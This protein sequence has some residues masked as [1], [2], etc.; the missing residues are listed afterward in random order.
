MADLTPALVERA[1]DGDDPACRALIDALTPT[2][3]A[4]VYRALDRRAAL[5]R[6]R[7]IRQEVLDMTQDVFLALFADDGRVLRRWDPARGA[8]LPTFV[9]LV[10]EREVRAILRSRRRSPW[11][12]DP[13]APD[14]LVAASAPAAAE[15]R[16]GDKETLREVL[17]RLHDRLSDRG[18]ELFE[19]LVVQGR[20]VDEVA[21]AHGMTRDAVY[22]W[23]SRLKKTVAA[24][25][26]DLGAQS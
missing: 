16:V 4:R 1:L 5:G 7:V 21:A 13:T 25:A 9:G 11:T 8:A 2:I 12:E 24:I 15:R 23:R 22:T 3:R 20:P 14:D 19:A 6:G 17:A 26:A 10:A 18:L